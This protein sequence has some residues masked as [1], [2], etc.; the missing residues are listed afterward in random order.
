MHDIVVHFVHRRIVAGFGKARMEGNDNAEFLRPG[1]CEF[2]A[3]PDSGA[4]KE[5]QR[6]AAAGGEHH[7]LHAV[8]DVSLAIKLCERIH[9]VLPYSAAARRSDA[10]RPRKR[11]MTSC[12]NKLRFFTTFQF[13]M[14]PMAPSMTKWLVPIRSPHSSS[15]S[16]TC[17]AV[18]T[19]TKNDSLMAWKLKPPCSLSASAARFFNWSTER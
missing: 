10:M 5:Q 13:G 8:D 7:R 19:A 16:A 17:S 9:G 11:G 15:C 2:E 18:P 14:L 12:A 6:L 3:V 1:Q 4:V